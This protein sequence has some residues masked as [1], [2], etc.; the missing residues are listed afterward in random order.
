MAQAQVTTWVNVGPFNPSWTLPA[1]CASI[2]T[3]LPYN[4][5][6]G[7]YFGGCDPKC[8]ITPT[9][10]PSYTLPFSYFSPAACPDGYVSACEANGV[11]T[12]LTVCCQR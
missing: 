5:V 10:K 6:V 3:K 2:T 11:P 8:D 12:G 4:Y 1:T 7:C 9:A